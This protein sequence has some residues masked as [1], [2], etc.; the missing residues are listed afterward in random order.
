VNGRIALLSPARGSENIGDAFIEQAVRRCLDPAVEF[1]PVTTRRSLTG[2]EIA[3]INGSDAVLICGTNLYQEHWQ[4]PAMDHAFF[5]GVKVPVI[6]FGVGSSAAELTEVT[7]PRKTRKLVRKV[8][9]L[10]EVG[11][12]RD[13]HTQQ[14]VERSGASNS[15]MTA[16]PVLH[17]SQS[18]TAPD[19]AAGKPTRLVITAR[20]W[21]MHRPGGDIDNPVQID[22]LRRAVDEFR[23]RGVLFVLHEPFDRSLIAPLGL[24][25]DEVFDSTDVTAFTELYAD[26][27]NVV[28]A[29]R[30][31]AGMLA[32]A[33]GV[34]GVF[35]GHDTRTYSFCEMLR[36]PYVR[37]FE[38]GAADQTLAALHRL[39][40]R[41]YS[42]FD[43]LQSDYLTHRR[44]MARFLAANGLPANESLRQVA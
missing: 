10:C 43:G 8:H 25:S 3:E 30:L 7:L 38:P 1:V 11:S 33:N 22:L 9:D 4:G 21:L 16:C 17:W 39:F 26:Q 28:L 36:M 31:H 29:S 6:P 27:T 34:P 32:A 14:V 40:D 37:L 5:K 15:I 41:D 42:A 12:A 20:N 13:P 19:P 18:N 24:R 44:E 23:D 2:A 35:V